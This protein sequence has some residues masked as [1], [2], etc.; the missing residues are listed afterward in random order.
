[1]RGFIDITGQTF[2]HIHVKEHIGSD[3]WGEAIFLCRC[4]ECGKEFVAK[5]SVIRYGLKKS[6]GCVAK[7]E[8][9]ERMKGQ[10]PATWKHGEG[11]SR[12][13]AIWS[14]MKTRCTNPNRKTYKHY[15]G[16]GISV[17]DEWFNSY[18]S[19]RDWALA[20][21]YRDDLTIERIDVNGDYEPSNCRWCTWKEQANN[22]TNNRIIKINGVERTLSEWCDIYGI[23]ETTVNQRLNA[24]GWDEERAVT[25]P[26]H[27]NHGGRVRY[28]NL[29][30]PQS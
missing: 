19:F 20:N 10:R 11:K 23:N 15:G 4:T 16:R 3:K 9:S 26:V 22:K 21:G 14:G 8:L 7:K 2:N 18:E 25:E 30:S 29:S 6:C 12:L 1:M 24:Y 27:N 28:G 13:F 5:S 17:C